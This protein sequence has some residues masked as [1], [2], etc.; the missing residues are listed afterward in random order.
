[1]VVT[2]YDFEELVKNNERRL[3]WITR[4]SIEVRGND[5][6]DRVD[7]MVARAG[8]YFGRDSR[9]LIRDFEGEVQIGD[10]EVVG[11]EPNPRDED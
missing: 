3:R 9:G 4:M 6:M 10:L 7:E 5:F 11:T 8:G 2:A 1:M